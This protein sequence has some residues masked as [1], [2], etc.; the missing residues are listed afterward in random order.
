MLKI[1]SRGKVLEMQSG[2]KT[3]L[4]AGLDHNMIPPPAATKAPGIQLVSASVVDANN[5]LLKTE[6]GLAL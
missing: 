1:Y 2:S 6:V 5:L 3:R 4:R